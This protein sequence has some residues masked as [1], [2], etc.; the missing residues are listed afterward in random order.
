[1]CEWMKTSYLKRYYGQNL[2]VNEDMAD[3]NQDGLTGW[4]K[5]QGKCVV[6]IGGRML[7][8]EVT[9]NICLRRPRPT[10]DCRADDDD[11]DDDDDDGDDYDYDNNNDDDDADNDDD[12]DDDDDQNKRK[13][14]SR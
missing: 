7:R 13:L 9:G 10:Q 12:D 5:T 14:D 2:E 6:E 1:M 3:R 8:I 4:R 11:D